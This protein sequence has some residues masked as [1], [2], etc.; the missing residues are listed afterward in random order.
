MAKNKLTDLNDHLF[1]QLERLGDEALK[2]D[3]L[4]GEIERTKAISLVAGKVIGNAKIQLDAI[5]T[6]KEWNIKSGP[7][8]LG[9]TAD[10]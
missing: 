1:A 2:G 9:I 5:K 7:A 8:M 4:A 10:K 6:A 3:A